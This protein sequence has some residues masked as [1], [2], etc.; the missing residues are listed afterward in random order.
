MINRVFAEKIMQRT[1][2]I[3]FSTRM[4]THLS[5]LSY[6][7]QALAIIK[8]VFGK[9][10]NGFI[11][12]ESPDLQN[13]ITCTGIEVVTSFPE[14]NY[15][16]RVLERRMQ[17]EHK[18]GND[19]KV[20]A[21]KKQ[22]ETKEGFKVSSTYQVLYPM[23]HITEEETLFNAVFQKTKKINQY[24]NK[25]F[26]KIGLFVWILSPVVTDL[27]N[28]LQKD[29]GELLKEGSAYFDQ[30]FDF[31]IISAERYVLYF[32]QYFDCKNLVEIPYILRCRLP[33][34][35]R[36]AAEGLIADD[37]PIWN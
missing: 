7:Y 19:D 27:F 26:H 3:S 11:K 32:N 23:S 24:K 36:M 10:L 37:D 34:F 9:E 33:T 1:S 12:K 5:K 29:L 16:T 8:L 17:D 21:L 15:R 2:N 20:K 28:D 31:T 35:G 18:N 6:E 13:L 4:D 30:Q 25:G 22:I 14:S